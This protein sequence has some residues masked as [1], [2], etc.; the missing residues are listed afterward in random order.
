METSESSGPSRSGQFFKHMF[1][2]NDEY[3]SDVLNVIQYALLAIVP[4]VALNKVMQKFVPEADDEK[5]SFELLAEVVIQ[6]IVMFL[7]L[8]F[9][10]RFIIYVPTYSGV[11]YKEFSILYSVLAILMITFSLQTKMG[12]KISIL[13]ERVSE[14]WEGKKEE[15]DKKGGKKKSGS[16]VK[17]KQPIVQPGYGASS[18]AVTP[19]IMN[20]GYSDGTSINSLPTSDPVLNNIL[21]QTAMTPQ[22]EYAMMEPMPANAALGSSAFSNW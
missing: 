19:S 16:G 8:I 5:G 18:L 6:V 4:V 15:K 7:G 10:D 11:K 20:Q 17:V 22:G 14:L 9:I 12:E 2:F 13:Y 21:P 3:K 1:G